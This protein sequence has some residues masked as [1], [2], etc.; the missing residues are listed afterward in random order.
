MY[1]NQWQSFF[2]SLPYSSSLVHEWSQIDHSG[3][4]HWSA[5]EQALVTYL[6]S[7]DESLSLAKR[8]ACLTESMKSFVALR[9][10]NDRHIATSFSLIRIHLE[11]GAPQAARAEIESAVHLMPWLAQSLP[12]DLRIRVNRPFLAPTASCE[13]RLIEDDLG[14][15]LQWAIVKSIE[16]IDRMASHHGGTS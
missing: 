14:N 16:E 11:E 9:E 8:Y 6:A 7:R 3:D 1:Q 5:Y 10:Q 12:R 15:W 4:I 2:T 13:S